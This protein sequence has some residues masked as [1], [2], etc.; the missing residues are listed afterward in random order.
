[1]FRELYL[2]IEKT[3]FFTLTR[4]IIGNLTFL[5]LF[6]V[7]AL[8]LAFSE[9]SWAKSSV[10]HIVLG[11][12]SV[13]VFLFTLFYMHYLIVRPVRAMVKNLDEIN[14]KQGDLSGHLPAFTHDEFRQLSDGY[15]TFV[16]NLSTL[17][18]DISNHA[19][20]ASTKNQ[21]VL[22][23]VNNASA[24]ARRQDKIS[25][26]IFA[27]SKQV[28][29]EIQAIVSRTD[30][31]ADATKDNLGAA[32]S[33][34]TR[35]VQLS[36]DISDIDG[37]LKEFDTTVGGMKDN[38]DN[39]RNILKMVQEFSD[40]TNLLALNAAIEA[41]RAGEAGRGFAV[42]AD[43]VRTLSVKVNEA[44]GQINTFINQME[45]L[46]KNTQ[47]E[48]VKL[49]E[50][51]GKA[52]ADISHTNDQ[53]GQMVEQ[54]EQNTERLAAIGESVHALRR[55]YDAAHESVANISTLGAEIRYDMQQVENEIQELKVE[56]ETTQKKLH[57]FL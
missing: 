44:T 32:Q 31:V 10:L 42:V 54:L 57:R 8:W 28:N 49:T 35:L 13:L 39:I 15:N 45:G 29:E 17:L 14:H 27:S 51:A 18:K 52:Q 40:Q 26:D 46:V 37:L 41:A 21:E 56:T 24:N 55:T 43:E 48:S 5:Y 16:D 19:L 20:G 7:V 4:K 36:S 34:M 53:F 33:S 47:Q 6:Q 23:K 12:M 50:V 22:L 3:F 1:M 30:E 9:S 2:F 25:D 11:V 38:A